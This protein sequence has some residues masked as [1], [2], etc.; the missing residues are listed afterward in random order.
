MVLESLQEDLFIDTKYVSRWSILAKLLGK[1]VDNHYSTTYWI[2][3]IPETTMIYALLLESE[4]ALFIMLRMS[5]EKS[6][7]N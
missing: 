4:E 6:Q 3:N 1:S 7:G 2:A 5:L